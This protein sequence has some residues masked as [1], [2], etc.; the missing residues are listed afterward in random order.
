[1]LTALTCLTRKGTMSSQ[2]RA[3]R[4]LYYC[5]TLLHGDALL[6][7]VFCSCPAEGKVD[8]PHGYRLY[9]L[10]GVSLYRRT[11]ARWRST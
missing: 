5:S 1:M 3:S 8:C 4:H 7:Y 11:P 9:M 10:P 6:R 2:V